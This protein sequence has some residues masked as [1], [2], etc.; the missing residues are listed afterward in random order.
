MRAVLFEEFAGP[1]SVRE[2]HNPKPTD[3]GVVIRVLA[4]GLCRSDWHGWMGHDSD[5]QLPHVPGHEFAG[6][7][8]SVGSQVKR[9]RPGDRVTVP[10]CVG[11]GQCGACDEG[12][13]QVCDRYFQ[14]GFTA[15]G[16][17]AEQVAIPHADFNLVKLPPE[18]DMTCAAGLG[19]RYVTAYHGL[20]AQAKLKPGEWLAVHGCGGV[21]LSAIQIGVALGAKVIAVD[22]HTDA[23]EW[24][25][26]FGAHATV[27][28]TAHETDASIQQIRSASSGGVHVSIDAIGGGEACRR[29]IAS[30]RKRGRH[31]QVGLMVA[32]DASTKLPMARVLAEELQVIGS[33]GIAA[34]EY[35]KLLEQ[36]VAGTLSPGQ[37][38]N[39]RIRLEDIPER[40][41][42]LGE[43]QHVGVTVVE[44]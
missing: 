32:E 43:N 37:L 40:L 11:C 14:P 21:G 25:E 13:P 9:F 36:I 12:H 31:V 2:L 33:H 17:F 35:P 5:V 3:D 42:R 16:S 27:H 15:W 26:R 7:I 10:F 34:H 20:V 22:V 41:P 24:A 4:T 18:I 39:E 28:V 23:L 8:E 38:V 1:L 29:S 44:F 30:L 6:V 19:C